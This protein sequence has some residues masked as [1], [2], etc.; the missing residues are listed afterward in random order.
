MDG[1]AFWAS[2]SQLLICWYILPAPF[3]C[4][5]TSLMTL[6]KYLNKKA[7]KNSLLFKIINSIVCFEAKHL[8]LFTRKDEW[9]TPTSW[10]TPI[11]ISLDLGCFHWVVIYPAHKSQ[12][13]Q[14]L[15]KPTA[16]PRP[17]DT[18]AQKHTLTPRRHL[19]LKRFSWRKKRRPLEEK[20]LN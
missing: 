8:K 20:G 4:H 14:W 19:S 15:Q 5:S 17:R 7:K 10:N 3:L 2:K 11:G 1:C 13:G 12:S 9:T 18:H 6:Y 16:A